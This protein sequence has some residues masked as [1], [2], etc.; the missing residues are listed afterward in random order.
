[1]STITP[2]VATVGQRRRGCDPPQQPRADDDAR[3]QLADDRRLPQPLE[4]LAHEL[5]GGEHHQQ[6]MSTLDVSVS[7]ILVLSSGTRTNTLAAK[8]FRLIAWGEPALS[9]ERRRSETQVSR[10]FL[11]DET[12]AK[13][14]PPTVFLRHFRHRRLGETRTFRESPSNDVRRL[15]PPEMTRRRGSAPFKEVWALKTLLTRFFD[16][17]A[18]TGQWPRSSSVLLSVR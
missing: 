18:I 14:A 5:A 13:C 12:A 6:A 3:Q 8:C 1:M 16:P 17:S 7:M 11:A 10:A 9:F 15:V 2:M 4:H